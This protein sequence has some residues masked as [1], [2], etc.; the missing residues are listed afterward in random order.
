MIEIWS[1]ILWLTNMKA[2]H[3]RNFDSLA[4]WIWKIRDKLLKLL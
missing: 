1:T 3:L 2:D 4:T